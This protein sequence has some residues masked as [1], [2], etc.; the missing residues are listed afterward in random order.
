[1]HLGVR[2]QFTDE[3]HF[4]NPTPITASTQPSFFTIPEDFR[5]NERVSVLFLT[6]PYHSQYPGYL[7]SRLQTLQTSKPDARKVLLLK[8]E[9]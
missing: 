3:I 8:Y 1:M 7:A 5:V 6:L 2:V 4:T 9:E